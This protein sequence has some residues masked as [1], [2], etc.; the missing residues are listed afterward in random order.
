MQKEKLTSAELVAAHKES[1]AALAARARGPKAQSVSVE[2]GNLILTL[3]GGAVEGTRL[4]IPIANL[5]VVR[6]IS[7]EDLPNVRL[8][9]GGSAIFW[10]TANV[11]F[12]TYGLVEHVTGIRSVRAHLA[13]AGS[14][15]TPAKIAAARENGK[16][17]GRPRKP[18]QDAG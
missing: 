16:K 12:A 9:G 13:Q 10:P 17:G 6:D 11:D 18:K 14:A 8:L 4:S 15:R 2:A 1:S 5:P 7:A 3:S